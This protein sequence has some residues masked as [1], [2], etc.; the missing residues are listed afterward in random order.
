MYWRSLRDV[1][2]SVVRKHKRVV[3]SFLVTTPYFF[4]S[5]S[6]DHHLLIFSFKILLSDSSCHFL[7]KKQKHEDLTLNLHFPDLCIYFLC[8]LTFALPFKHMK[9][10]LDLC[11]SS[12]FSWEST[13]LSAPKTEALLNWERRLPIVQ[14]ILTNGT[15][16][17]I[18]LPDFNLH[19]IKYT[20]K[21]PTEEWK[22]DHGNDEEVA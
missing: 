5:N 13:V 20:L 15:Q 8:N 9:E 12:L 1:G 19:E 14:E 10:L 7:P 21:L 17:Q 11:L 3:Q 2:S 6:I 22:L 18:V 16:L 4:L